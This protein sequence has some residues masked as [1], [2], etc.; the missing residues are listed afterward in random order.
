IVPSH[1]SDA[2]SLYSAESGG[3]C[4]SVFCHN[5][6]EQK[7]CQSFFRFLAERRLCYRQ[8]CILFHAELLY[9]KCQ[10]Q[11]TA[12]ACRG[13]AQHMLQGVMTKC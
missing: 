6:E 12:P 4:L 11:R 8:N 1:D 9:R 2:F 3:K 5:K 10:I 7:V 13:T